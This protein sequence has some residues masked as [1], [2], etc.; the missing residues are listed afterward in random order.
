MLNT[1]SALRLVVYGMGCIKACGGDISVCHTKKSFL[2]GI[3]KPLQIN[4]ILKVTNFEITEFMCN[5][6]K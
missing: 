2:M 1:E 3:R 6:K 5:Y 4:E